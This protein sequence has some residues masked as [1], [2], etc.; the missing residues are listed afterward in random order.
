MDTLAAAYCWGD[1]AV[2]QLGT[3]TQG[4]VGEYADYTSDTPLPVA[5]EGGST[6]PFFSVSAGDKHTCGVS[7]RAAPAPSPSASPVA[8]NPSPGAGGSGSPAEQQ[9]SS[10]SSFPVGAVVGAVVGA[11][12]ERVGGCMPP[13][14]VAF[15]NQQVEWQQRHAG[16]PSLVVNP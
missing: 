12:G 10:S 8:S 7:S 2:G 5:Q 3:G 4:R 16:L 15:D 9:S 6:I 13:V 11:A 1:G 14:C